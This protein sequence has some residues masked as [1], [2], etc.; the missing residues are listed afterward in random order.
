MNNTGKFIA[1]VQVNGRAMDSAGNIIDRDPH[2]LPT[3]WLNVIAGSI[4][5]RQTLTGSVVQRM[6]VPLDENGVIAPG[7]SRGYAFSK[8]LIYGQWLHQSTHEIYGP[9]YSWNVIKDMTNSSVEDIEKACE[10][11]GPADVFTVDRPD[12]P[13]DY[14]R[15]TVQHVGRRKLDPLDHGTANQTHSNPAEQARQ[16]V[17]EFRS[18]KGTNPEVVIVGNDSNDSNRQ[19]SKPINNPN[20][21]KNNPD[22]KDEIIS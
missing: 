11:V 19:P 10:H 2:G 20:A 13:E 6:G 4:P 12:L 18:D 5:N 21:G 1:M 15:K 7:E 3:M 22:N 17:G 8:R 14:Q 16:E 9:Q